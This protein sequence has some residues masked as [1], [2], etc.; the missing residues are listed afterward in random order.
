M[1]ETR[2]SVGA[3]APDGTALNINGEAVEIATLWRDGP[4]L[5]TFLRHFG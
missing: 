4:V 1:K 2:L 3:N 5:L